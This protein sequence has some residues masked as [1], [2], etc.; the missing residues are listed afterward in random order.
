MLLM[1]RWASSASRRHVVSIFVLDMCCRATWIWPVCLSDREMAAGNTFGATA[2]SSY[3]AFRSPCASPSL[4]SQSCQSLR[5]PTMGQL[6]FSM[7]RMGCFLCWSVFTFL[8][9]TCTVKSTAVFFSL[10]ISVDVAFLLL[11][12]GHIRSD[13]QGIPNHQ[14]SQLAVYLLPLLRFW[15]GILPWQV[16]RMTPTA[17]SSFLSFISRG[18]RNVGLP[19]AKILLLFSGYHYGRRL[20]QTVLGTP[21]TGGFGHNQ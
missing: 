4:D 14:Y 13:A 1:L 15:R 5:T 3:S 20:W 2:L 17:F 16:S 11:G 21:E 8:L 9:L 12:I 18:L 6:T 10:F 7:T 19:A